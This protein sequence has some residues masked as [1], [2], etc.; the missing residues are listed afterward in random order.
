MVV[1]VDVGNS[2][3][4]FGIYNQ[5]KIEMSFR[6]KSFT[7]KTSDEYYALVYP[8]IGKYKIEEVIIS[9][10]V[11]VITSA[12]SKLFKQYY[13]I[14]AIIIGPGVKN[15]IGIKVDEPKSVGSDLICDTAGIMDSKPYIIVDLG[16]ATKY[17]YV[18]DRTLHGV[19]IAPGVITSLNALVSS[20]ALLPSVELQIPSKVLGKN[21]ISC[22]QSGIIFGS[23]SQ[24]DGM[25]DRILEE[26]QMPEVG[27]IATGGLSKTIIPHCKHNIILDEQL[28]LR[29]IIN[30][31]KL[32]KKNNKYMNED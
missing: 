7:D 28:V 23:A 12:L 18:K 19:V 11:P 27:I 1:L 29:G 25:I 6:L 17:L 9:S 2:S 20:A 32:N 13:S 26:I 14:S 22:M 8:F 24:I 4:Y 5:E 15:G 3:I 31:Y 21:T 16:T 10:V 30:I